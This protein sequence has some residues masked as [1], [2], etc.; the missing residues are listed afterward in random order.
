MSRL[1][2]TGATGQVGAELCRTL[3]PLGEVLALGRSHLDLRQ[4]DLIRQ[5]VRRLR[6][7]LIVNAAAYTA[8]DRA[9]SEPDLAMAVNA[10]APTVLAE[11]AL[12]LG[13]PLLH[14]ST[15]YV[16]DGTAHRPYHETDPTHPLNVY[17]QSKAQGE[18]GIGATGGLHAIVRTAWVYGVYGQS[19]FVKTILRLASERDELRIVA[20]QIGSPTWAAD[21]AEAIATIVRLWAIPT[22]EEP[23]RLIH[24]QEGTGGNAHTTFPSV[25]AHPH[26]TY[27]LTNSG[28]A[29]WYDLA[30][31]II[32]EA[33][34]L[35]LPLRVQ[36]ILP[37]T[38]AD[39]PTPA[40]RPPYSVLSN[41]RAIALLGQPLPHWR[42]SLR[43]MLAALIPTLTTAPSS[44]PICP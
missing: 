21:L 25:A 22:D 12:A 23:D 28:V 42:Q 20:D 43:R 24:S 3:S 8:V 16:F 26:G 10:I 11:E 15:D 33:I 41:Q 4:P 6:P 19:N 29:S 17:G 14:L 9:E 1:L 18:A 13:I 39:Y 2:L 44:S 34:A 31:A 5:T 37:N 35:G 36:R 27:H 38:T 32:E 7:S 30:V 40:Q